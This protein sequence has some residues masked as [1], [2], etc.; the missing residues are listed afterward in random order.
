MT[1]PAEGLSDSRA[2][3]RQ[4]KVGAPLDIPEGSGD[5]KLLTPDAKRGAV[6]HVLTAHGLSERRA[7][8]LVALDRA[9]FQYHKKLFRPHLAQTQEQI[10][11][12]AQ[13]S[14]V[15]AL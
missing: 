9:A 10:W 1:A 12:F 8:Q 6:R 14:R 4:L 7:C 15:L 13:V 5:K 3:G 11:Y 2:S